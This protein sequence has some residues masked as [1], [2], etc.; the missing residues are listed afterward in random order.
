MGFGFAL[1]PTDCGSI[2][3]IEAQVEMS[4]QAEIDRIREGGL[5]PTLPRATWNFEIDLVGVWR[6][7]SGRRTRMSSLDGLNS[8]ETFAARCGRHP[9]LWARSNYEV[10]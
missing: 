7:N 5:C 3:F 10:L 8:C 6:E 9:S 4:D 2:E 1:H